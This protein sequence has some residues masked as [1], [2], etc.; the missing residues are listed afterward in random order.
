MARI[1]EILERHPLFHGLPR[2]DMEPLVRDCRLRTPRRGE[3]LF[4]SREPA[5][6]FFL[7]AAGRVK[8]SRTNPAGKEHVV[9]VIRAGETFALMPVLEPGGAFPVDATALG[10]AAV[11]RIPRE[12]FQRLL[13]RRPEVRTRATGEVAERLRRF[14]TRLEEV[15]TLSVEARVASHLLRLAEKEAGSSAP[16]TVVDLA[17]SREVAAASLGTVREVL[18]RTLRS[19]EKDGVVALRGRRIEILDPD[20]LRSLAGR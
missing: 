3:R 13:A 1:F 14:T 20:R 2:E 11:V 4:S 19:L 6:A 12:A 5:D 16:G 17:A 7:V 10:D 8:L 9:E 15:A 18:I